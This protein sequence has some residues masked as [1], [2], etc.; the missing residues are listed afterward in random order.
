M[1]KE[2]EDRMRRARRKDDRELMSDARPFVRSGVAL[3]L[4]LRFGNGLTPA[5]CYDF[6][7]MFL[8]QLDKDLGDESA[9][10]A[11]PLEDVE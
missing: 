7:D 4:Y 8:R 3:A 10:N 9:G 1:D 6:A 11:R 2:T 5:S